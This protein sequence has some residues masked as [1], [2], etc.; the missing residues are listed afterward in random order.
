MKILYGIQ[1]TGNGHIVRA[2]A[3]I[4]ILRQMGHDVET[5]LSGDSSKKILNA[6]VFKPA[7]IKE[8]LTFVSDKGKVKYLQTLKESNLVK[9]YADVYTYKPND[10]DLIITDYEPITARIAKRYKIP[11]IGIGHLYSFYYDVPISDSS[12]IGK[13]V[14]QQFAPAQI[15]LGLHWHHFNQPILP[16]TIPDDVKPVKNIKKNKILVY[17]PFENLA[18][19]KRM[20][21]K[22]DDHHF[23]IYCN[24]SKA[25]DEG[26]LHLRPFSRKGF[27][28]DLGECNGLVCNSGF[29]LISEALH[30][31]KKVLTKP[32]EAQT[33]QESNAMALEQLGLGTVVEKLKISDI[34][35]WLLTDSPEPMNF[36][37]VLMPLAE[38]ISKGEWDDYESLV[39]RVWQTP[40]KT[41]TK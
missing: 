30:L 33:E 36:P 23:Y 17:L 32:L 3:M 29:S 24:I 5:I 28:K 1:T 11:S 25:S 31:G 15:P 27:V 40:V 41:I 38:W 10:V 22:I 26:N 14:M 21:K 19:I 4:K 2:K 9:F 34:R 8:G 39:N 18:S 35:K 16:P 7:Q 37:D 12:V 6:D 20:L 13:F